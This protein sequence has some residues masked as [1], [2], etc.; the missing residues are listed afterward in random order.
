MTRNSHNT[1]SRRSSLR[2]ISAMLNERAS[3]HNTTPGAPAYTHTT[4]RISISLFFFG[5]SLNSRLFSISRLALLSLSLNLISSSTTS[6]SHSFHPHISHHASISNLIQRNMFSCLPVSCFLPY[7][8]P[9]SHPLLYTVV[10]V[11]SHAVTH[12]TS[13][14][15]SLGR[16]LLLLCT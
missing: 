4:H 8:V 5:L 1:C 16:K 10:V 6:T 12:H 7:S 3:Q 9:S 13:S 2:W 14:V 11:V 15:S